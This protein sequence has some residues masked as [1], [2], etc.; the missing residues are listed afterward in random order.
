MKTHEIVRYGTFAGSAAMILA[1]LLPVT[2]FGQDRLPIID[3]HNAQPAEAQEPS[4]LAIHEVT[5][6][7]VA[8]GSLDPSQ[9]VLIR[10]NMIETIGP[11]A[12]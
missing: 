11:G 5:G 10:G 6:V 4:L 9:T 3:M 1:L 8:A 2:V 7:D 12:G